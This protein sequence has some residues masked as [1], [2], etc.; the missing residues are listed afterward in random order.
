MVTVA[1]AAN[2]TKHSQPTNRQSAAGSQN[3]AKTQRSPEEKFWLAASP[4]AP[5]PA[6]CAPIALGP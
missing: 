5:A 4:V 1:A 6:S 2:G 3:S